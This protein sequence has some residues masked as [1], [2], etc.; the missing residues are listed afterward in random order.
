MLPLALQVILVRALVEPVQG[1]FILFA[2]NLCPWRVV[3]HAVHMS[4]TA[5]CSP[6]DT[7]SIE[8]SWASKSASPSNAASLPSG[9]TI[10]R[11]RS[12]LLDPPTLDSG[13]ATP[14]YAVT[15]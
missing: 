4:L 5:S 10:M 13:R 8:A 11:G 6:E 1:V 9:P 14:S 12:Q 2:V 7:A 3:L 15:G